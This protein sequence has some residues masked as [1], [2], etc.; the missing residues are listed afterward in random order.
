MN[1]QILESKIKEAATMYYTSSST[2]MDDKE[3][4]NLIVE[5]RKIDPENKLLH[6]PGWGADVSGK[7]KVGLL[8]YGNH[9]LSKIKEFPKG[10]HNKE[11][12][13]TPKL[14]GMSVFI[15]WNKGKLVRACTREGINIFHHIRRIVPVELPIK[16]TVELRGEV[17]I[18]RSVF[19]DKYS[20]KY[21]NPRNFVAGMINR[22]T[23]TEEIKDL[24]VVFYQINEEYIRR[25][26]KIGILSYISSLGLEVVEE[27]LNS[28]GVEELKIY[29]DNYKYLCD[30]LVITDKYIGKQ[31]DSI[32]FKFE[33]ELHRTIVTGIEWN[34]GDTGRIVPTVHYSPIEVEGSILKK[35]SGFNYEF[36]IKNNIAIGCEIEVKK[37]N[38]IIP[39]IERVEKNDLELVIPSLC[40][41]CNS[42]L[43][44]S[45]MD[46][47]CDNSIY[48]FVQSDVS[49]WRIFEISGEVKGF[50]TKSFN[51]IKEHF[52]ATNCVQ[53][54]SVSY[55]P[56][57]DHEDFGK[58]YYGRLAHKMMSM[59]VDKRSG[60]YSISEFWYLQGFNGL[61]KSN[62][63]KLEKLGLHP[64]LE[65]EEFNTKLEGSKINKNVKKIITEKRTEWMQCLPIINVHESNSKKQEYKYSVCITGKLSRKRKDLV[66]LLEVNNIKVTG[67]VNSS[68]DFLITNAVSSS[69]KYKKAVELGIKIVSE[70]EFIKIEGINE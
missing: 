8:I 7:S 24:K 55:I 32:A 52:K 63:K 60:G 39:Y 21:S 66:E 62:S 16:D 47:V 35:A 11:S 49:L 34:T 28:A 3:F 15:K 5:L 1:K 59:M 67:G 6:T 37:S 33:D 45:R 17:V 13:I 30:G 44:V 58:S 4:D 54:L 29:I 65:I 43:R 40:P 38:K 51:I 56:T 48:C 9:S 18:D 14:D 57:I 22:E 19:K 61:G 50:S 20:E 42:I 41:C 26:T 31:E 27:L 12:V 10:L 64:L 2:I 68:V 70:D 53:L 69:S 46:L 36:I 23:I 25:D